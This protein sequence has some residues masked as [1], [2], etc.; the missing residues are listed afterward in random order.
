MFTRHCRDSPE[1]VSHADNAQQIGKE[2]LTKALRIVF[3]NGQLAVLPRRNIFETCSMEPVSFRPCGLLSVRRI[4]PPRLLG[5]CL[6]RSDEGGAEEGEKKRA[7][8][9]W[10]QTSS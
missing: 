1:H 6:R 8:L 5:S 4:W 7:D 2:S 3:T 9:C 10:E